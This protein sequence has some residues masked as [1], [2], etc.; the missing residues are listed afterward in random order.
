MLL[1][2]TVNGNDLYDLDHTHRLYRDSEKTPLFNQANVHCLKTKEEHVI[3]LLDQSAWEVY[4]ADT[5]VSRY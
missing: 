1:P 5:A 4:S 3:V 2:Y